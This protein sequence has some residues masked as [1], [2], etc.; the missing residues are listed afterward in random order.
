MF[1]IATHFGRIFPEYPGDHVDVVHGA[2]VED[3]AADL[4]VVHGG[5]R[6][7]AR[8]RLDH[9]HVAHTPRPHLGP[10]RREARVKPPVEGAE[11]RPAHL[12]GHGPIRDEY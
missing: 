6:G 8:G 10:H 7:V 12:W 1:L 11:Q 5:Q 4:E 9:L 2:V 3:A